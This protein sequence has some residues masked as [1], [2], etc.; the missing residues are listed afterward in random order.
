M[1]K[2]IKSEN[3]D[4]YVNVENPAMATDPETNEDP[5]DVKVAPPLTVKELVLKYWAICIKVVELVRE[6]EIFFEH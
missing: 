5:E 4:F 2:S 6:N 1:K 3:L